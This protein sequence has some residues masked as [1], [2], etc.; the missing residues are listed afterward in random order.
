MNIKSSLSSGHG[1]NIIQGSVSLDDESPTNCTEIVPGFH[2]KIGEW[3]QAVPERRKCPEGPVVGIEKPGDQ[4]TGQY[5]GSLCRCH[6]DSDEGTRSLTCEVALWDGNWE[7]ESMLSALNATP[8]SPLPLP[9]LSPILPSFQEYWPPA[10]YQLFQTLYLSMS[11]RH[12]HTP[13]L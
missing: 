4:R 5:L 1:A 11:Y 6:V 12:H 13:T 9:C 10:F 8:P 3:W 7:P 2:K